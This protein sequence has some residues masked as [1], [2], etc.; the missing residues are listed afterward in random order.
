MKFSD[1]PRLARQAAQPH[2][3]IPIKLQTSLSTYRKDEEKGVN[4]RNNS[5]NWVFIKRCLDSLN[6]LKIEKARGE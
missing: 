6:I 1:F 4:A 5:F 2:F 3:R